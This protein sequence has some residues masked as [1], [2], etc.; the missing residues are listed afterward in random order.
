VIDFDALEAAR[1][2]SPT[3][4]NIS[5]LARQFGD[6]AASWAFN[7]WSL[8]EKARRKFADPAPLLFTTDG[9]EQASHSAVATYHAGLYPEG[10]AVADLCCGIG[11]DLL[12]LA[13]RGPAIGFEIDAETAEYAA[14]NA[15]TAVVRRE[16]SLAAEW[17]F[18]HAF[19]DPSRRTGGRRTLDPSAFLPSPIDLAERMRRLKFGVVKLSPMLNDSYL[20]DISPTI[21]FVSF[22]WEC[23][24]AL[25]LIGGIDGGVTAV[26][27]ETGEILVS[28]GIANSVDE[29][30]K[31]IYEADPAAIRA[32]CLPPLCERMDAQ[33]L[34]DSNGYLTGENQESNS[35]LRSFEVSESGAFDPKRVKSA[36]KTSG[37]LAE[38]TS[39]AAVDI[40]EIRGKVSTGAKGEMTLML[41]PVGKSIRFAIVKRVK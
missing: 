14:H 8:R 7:Q 27:V 32:H 40:D 31:F 30:A 29:P 21:R 25:A 11:S 18:E 38:I 10:V 23:R 15:P 13:K 16:D 39:R 34:G 9:L 35:W 22:G 24:E 33:L 20:Q 17:D 12:A 28:G 19:A 2:V 4:N 36:L 5:R 1:G 41:Y 26:K 37:G 6:E 3:A